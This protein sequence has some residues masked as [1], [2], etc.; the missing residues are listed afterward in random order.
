MALDEAEPADPD[1]DPDP[2]NGT[3]AAAK[4]DPPGVMG[5]AVAPGA[6]GDDGD[7]GS[8]RSRVSLQEHEMA[9]LNSREIELADRVQALYGTLPFY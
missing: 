9:S 5:P 8:L 1:P 4:P 6:G 7:I 2:A 3:A